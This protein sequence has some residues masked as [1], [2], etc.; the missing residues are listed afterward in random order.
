MQ[1]GTSLHLTDPAASQYNGTFMFSDQI[2]QTAHSRT[3]QAEGLQLQTT[4]K[5]CRQQPGW[6]QHSRA[7]VAKRSGF[8]VVPLPPTGAGSARHCLLF[9]GIYL[10][11]PSACEGP[12]E[13]FFA[14]HFQRALKLDETNNCCT[15]TMSERASII[16]VVCIVNSTA[17]FLARSAETPSTLRHHLNF[18]WPA[19]IFSKCKHFLSIHPSIPSIHPSC[20]GLSQLKWHLQW[21][22]LT[23]TPTNGVLVALHWDF[24]ATALLEGGRK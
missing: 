10:L 16:Q 20:R 3:F 4:V 14:T 11:L 5:M 21:C 7:E 13:L 23:K 2:Q 19:P 24:M 18:Q 22:C 17:S 8:L 6:P 1:S 12:D 9:N 15:S